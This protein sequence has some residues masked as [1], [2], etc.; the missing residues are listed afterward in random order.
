MATTNST[1]SN[2]PI[3]NLQPYGTLNYA[4]ALQGIY[5]SR[6][7]SAGDNAL[8]GIEPMLGEVIEFA[9]NFAPRG[10]A[11]CE[12]QLLS[13]AQNTALFSI[14]GTYYGGNGQT[15]FGLPDLRGRTPIGT[16]QGAGLSIVDLGEPSGAENTTLT[17]DNLPAHLHSID[18]ALTGTSGSNSPT[19]I[20]TRQPTLGLTPL[21]TT[22]GIYEDIGE[23]SW[24]AGNFAPVGSLLANGQLLNIAEYDVLFS[25]IGTTYGGDGQTTFALPDLRGRVVVDDGTNHALGTTF[26]T[27]NVTLTVGNLPA[28]THTT[29]DSTTGTIGSGQSF[30]NL[31]PSIAIDFEI[32]TAGIYPSRNLQADLSTVTDP[33]AAEVTGLVTSDGI[34][35]EEISAESISSLA[36]VALDL[37]TAAG[38]SDA[39]KA[40]LQTIT[41]KIANLETGYLAI[42]GADNTI[43]I[44]ADASNTG[45]FVDDTP[46]DHLEFGS[47]DPRTGELLAT[48]R[49]AVSRY[50]LLTA[51]EHEQGHALNLAHSGTQGN[52]MFGSLGKGGRLFPTANNIIEAPG[53]NTA[54]PFFVGELDPFIAQVGMF[55]GSQDR[56]YFAD[57]SG[58]LLPINQNQALFS[59]L[60][61]TYGGN[62]QTTFALPNFRDRVVVGVGTAP[63]GSPFTQGSIG[64]TETTTLTTAQMPAHTHTFVGTP[65]ITSATYNASTGVLA[66]TGTEFLSLTGANNDIDVSKLTLTGE[67]GS[68]YTLTSTSVEISSGTS[69]TVTLNATDKA[70]VNQIVNKNGTSSTSATTYNLAAAE[71]WAAGADAA[72]VV[73]DLTGNGIT[74]SSVA[75]P[76]ITSSTY[77]ASTGVLTV[78]GTGFLSLAGATNDINVSKLT[79]TGEGGSTRTLTSTSVEITS[80][81]SFTVTLNTTDKAGVNAIVNK[82]GTSST[83]ATTYNLAAAEDWAAGADTAVVVADL[84]GN[85]I[86]ASNVAPTV[87]ITS[88]K[89]TFKAGETATVTFTFSEAPTGFEAN[90]ITTTGGSLT[91]LAVNPTNSKVYTA[92]FTPAESN[93]LNASIAIAASTF[94]DSASNSNLVGA[95]LAN[96]TGDTLKPIAPTLAL[97]SDTGASNTDKVT[98]VG[99]VSVSGLEASTNREYSVNNGNDWTAFNAQ[100]ALT[101]DGDKSVIVRQTDLSGNISTSSTALNFTLDTTAPT[102]GTLVFSDFSDTGSSSSDLISSDKNFTLSSTGGSGFSTVSYQLNDFSE[103]GYWNGTLA[104]QSNLIDRTYKYRSVYVDLAGNTSYSTPVSVKIDTTVP[105]LGASIAI[106]GTDITVSTQA[107]DNQIVGT[108]EI[109]STVT[110]KSGAINLG[111]FTT[112]ASGN[113]TYQLTADNLTTLGQ[114][115]NKSINVIATDVAGNTAQQTVNFTIDTVKPTVTITDDIT[116]TAN[117]ATTNVAYSYTFSEAVTGLATDDFTL[118]NGTISSITGSGTA[119]TVNVTPTT[120]VASGNIGLELKANAVI[121]AVGNSNDSVTDSSQSIDTA[122]P[123]VSIT[124]NVTG[125]ANLATT[126]VAYS[127]T[128]SEAVTGLATDNFT[129]TNGTISS[130]TGSGTAWTVNVTPTANVASGNIGL[131]L[132]ANAVTD[133]VGN[134]NDS[135]TNNSQSIDTIAPTATIVLAK[136]N[137]KYDNN[138]QTVDTSLVTISFSEAVTG[139]TNNDLSISNGSLSAV[140]S[141]DNGI[142]WT[143]TFTPTANLLSNTNSIQLSNTG[144]NDI[145]GN[146]GV[147]TTISSNYQIDTRPNRAPTVANPL[148]ARNIPQDRAFSFPIPTNT[149]NDLDAGDVLTYTTSPLPTWL[150]FNPNTGTFSGTP[151]TSDSN[152]SITVTATD[153]LLES[154]SSTFALNV[155]RPTTSPTPSAI[156]NGTANDDYLLGTAGNDKLYG[157][158]GNDFIYGGVGNDF[159]YGDDGDDLLNGGSGNDNLNGGTG[160]DTYQFDMATILPGLITTHVLNEAVVG[161][162]DTID[163]SAMSTP[164]KIDLNLKDQ[165]ATPELHIVIPILSLENVVGGSG[166]DMISGSKADNIFTGGAGNDEFRFSAGVL[167][168]NITA[169][170]AFGRDTIADFTRGEDKISLSKASFNLA[171]ATLSTSDFAVVANDAAVVG[172]ATKIVY[173]QSSHGL[174]LNDG[175]HS[176]Q[177]AIL[178]SNLNTLSVNDFQLV[179]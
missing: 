117:R 173:S 58:Q 23:I 63:G 121:D 96:L 174:F 176:G 157:K 22:E 129:I 10:Y 124:D 153:K 172:V 47:T 60:G 136:T 19:P 70:G 179:A 50:D 165:Y 119:W 26:G 102:A 160:N 87:T 99:T 17:S 31:Q 139:F 29:T 72:V 55:A 61:T 143:G 169:T 75:V 67:G 128:F 108:A 109:G 101:G 9:G 86:T 5:P 66:V 77:N 144:V 18:A 168:R 20:D 88:T 28:H 53:S 100:F 175:I 91:G 38:I 85:G 2:Q 114:G 4:I 54:S 16:G 98:S 95:S 30:S 8:S 127:Y 11:L 79:F 145:A 48:D 116:G 161:G 112:D 167:I 13:I 74:V 148:T 7:L 40:Q 65:T 147:G 138:S 146:A 152:L 62:G 158:A 115:N 52:V 45:W 83:S 12:G 125:T 69:F 82:N 64:G 39:Q 163:F 156:I 6:S 177:F 159:L 132:K 113:F 81:T 154:V 15:T 162:T 57:T 43:T 97:S 135:V 56:R 27:E 107:N 35:S 33:T 90:D 104:A 25:I 103:Q 34:L 166:N 120:N 133:A 21:I 106:G 134:S 51:I 131:E 1:G 92:T 118:T 123:T 42:Y 41:Y 32:A 151:A 89:T 155:I 37:W 76:T 49:R 141:T 14:I 105:T 178:A 3:S 24:F 44:D 170:Q 140:T 122:K 68:T 59:L 84:T 149:F 46:L 150:T 164:I 94:Q 78:T 93:S 73:A 137:L 111:S 36:Q 71:D 171:G 110:F 80:G 126:T 142:T 130:I